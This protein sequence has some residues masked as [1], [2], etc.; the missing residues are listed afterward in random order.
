[1]CLAARGLEQRWIRLAEEAA[2]RDMCEK[3]KPIS[4]QIARYRRLG[5][6]VSD[7]RTLDG[8]ARLIAE[9][10]DQKRTLHPEQEK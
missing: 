6:Q 5:A 7:A 2:P 10:E 8:I 1:M 9:L 4:D 3:C